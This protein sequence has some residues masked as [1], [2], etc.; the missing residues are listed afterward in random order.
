MEIP[1]VGT[2]LVRTN[3]AAVAFLNQLSDDTKGKTARNHFV[4]KLFASNVN[5][6]EMQIKDGT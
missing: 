1:F 6:H 4:N 2:F 3:I 5:K